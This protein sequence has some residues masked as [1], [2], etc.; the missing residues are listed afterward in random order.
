MSPYFK[1]FIAILSFLVLLVSVVVLRSDLVVQISAS[2]NFVVVPRK[3][4]T[5][6]EYSTGITILPK[7]DLEVETLE[8]RTFGH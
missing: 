3:E 4:T 8:N 2:F 5:T 6:K 1:Y 7:G